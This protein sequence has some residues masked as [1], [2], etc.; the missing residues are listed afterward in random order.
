MATAQITVDRLLAACAAAGDVT[1]R[2]MFG[3]Y[4]VYL[5][6]KP[7][8]PACDGRFFLKPTAAGEAVLPSLEEAPP[9]DGAKPHRVVPPELWGDAELMAR[10]LRT[11]HDALPAAKRKKT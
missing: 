5:D 2:K 1:A 8:G 9:Y 10:L 4:C 7:V 11:T 6:G 3:G